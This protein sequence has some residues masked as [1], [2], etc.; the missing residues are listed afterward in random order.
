MLH[1]PEDLMG[2]RKRRLHGS[3]VA[4]IVEPGEQYA[5]TNHNTT[6]ACYHCS[7]RGLELFLSSLQYVPHD[8]KR[9]NG[10]RTLKLHIR[11]TTAWPTIHPTQE[12]KLEVP[13]FIEPVNQ[14]P[15]IGIGKC[16]PKQLKVDWNQAALDKQSD[17]ENMER[18]WRWKDDETYSERWN[19]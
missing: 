4:D 2:K 19:A 14:E 18:S 1:D 13:I 9:E 11:N 8:A 17:P 5:Y 12:H 10:L 7:R 15:T 6:L 3:K 16:F